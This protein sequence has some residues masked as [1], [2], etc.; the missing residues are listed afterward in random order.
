MR[1]AARSTGRPPRSSTTVIPVSAI[2][3]IQKWVSGRP[4]SVSSVTL[5]TPS[6][7]TIT[8]HGWP[9]WPPDARVAADLR[10]VERS[11]RVVAAEPL[12]DRRQRRPDARLDVRERLAAGCPD[13]PRPAPPAGEHVRV[14]P[15]DLVLVEALPLALAELEEAA[16]GR[17]GT[18]TPSAASIASATYAAVCARPGERR[19]DDLQ[20]PDLR[21]G[22]GGGGVGPREALAGEGALAVAGRR[23]RGLRLALEPV[24]DDPLGLAV[25][26]QDERRVEALGDDRTRA[27]RARDGL[28]RHR[29]PSRRT[30]Q[31]SM[32]AS[33]D[34]IAPTT[35]AGTSSSSARTM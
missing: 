27:A 30:T 17:I 26:E 10:P 6:W 12:E 29:A 4:N 20:R 14:A 5:N 22:Q 23:E 34:S 18:R 2:V 9:A 13:L 16:V 15:R 21:D 3:N 1:F 19:V 35:E 32:T 31:T 24:L 25:A 33:S 7:P 11:A 8:V 28:A